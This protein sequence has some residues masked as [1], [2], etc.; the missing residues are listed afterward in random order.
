MHCNPASPR[1][2]TTSLNGKHGW[3]MITLQQCVGLKYYSADVYY[4][5]Q[6]F[7]Y[8]FGC[9][10]VQ[11]ILTCLVGLIFQLT[12]SSHSITVFICLFTLLWSV[13][14][15]NSI[16]L[17]R[18][19]FWYPL[20][21]LMWFYLDDSCDEWE[22]WMDIGAGIETHTTMPSCFVRFT[23]YR[24]LKWPECPVLEVVSPYT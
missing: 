11:Y 22:F 18:S 16:Y 20:I 14:G 9:W 15:S 6:I 4:D 5:M 2:S 13:H 24:E 17:A 7:L 19:F 21:S 3:E 23:G 12:L 1:L 10:A 8:I